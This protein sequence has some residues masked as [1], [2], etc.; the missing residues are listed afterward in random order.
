MDVPE[1]ILAAVNVNI[2]SVARPTKF[3]PAMVTVSPTAYPLPGL[4]TVT[5]VIWIVPLTSSA[6]TVKTAPEPVPLLVVGRLTVPAAILKSPKV[7]AEVSNEFDAVFNPLFPPFTNNKPLSV[8]ISLFTKRRLFIDTSSLKVPCVVTVPLLI[9]SV[10]P[11]I[12]ADGIL[13][14]GYC[15]YKLPHI[16]TFPDKVALPATSTSP[17]KIALLVTINLLFAYKSPFAYI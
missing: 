13:L 1:E 9:S 10:R 3:A 7:L 11:L 2:K 8:V 4:F 6:K 12:A 16:S 15:A 14:A 5:V 17:D